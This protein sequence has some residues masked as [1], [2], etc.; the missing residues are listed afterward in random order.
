MLIIIM[1]MKR[2]GRPVVSISGRIT[3][4]LYLFTLLVL[5]LYIQGSFQ[6]F[7]DDSLIRLLG[8]FKFSSLVYIASAM[9]YIVIILTAGRGTGRR[10]V[11]RAVCNPRRNCYYDS[12]LFHG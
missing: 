3:L 7:T 8:L 9:T 5:V 1:H 10:I 6:N 2:K 4:F 12:I 11:L